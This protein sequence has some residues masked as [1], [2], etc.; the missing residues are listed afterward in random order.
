MTLST[1]ERVLFL[2]SVEVFSAVSG[3]DL[4]PL[5]ALAQEIRLAPGEHFIRQGE[6]GDC[7][8]IIVDGEISITVGDDQV[9]VWGAGS[10]LGEMAVLSGQPRTAT[11]TALTDAFALQVDRD[12]FMEMLMEH[13]AMAIGVIGVL[14]HRLDEASQKLAR[15]SRDR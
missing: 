4:A 10:V 7:L 14:T 3:E 13:P 8:Y 2:Q 6:F 1:I 15:G 9:A 5:A 12:D 11:C